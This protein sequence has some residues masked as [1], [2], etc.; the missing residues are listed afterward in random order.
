MNRNRNRYIAKVG[1][2]EFDIG[3]TRHDEDYEIEYDGSKYNISFDKLSNG[4]FL[5]KVNDTV[6]EINISRNNGGLDV[7]ID[8]KE[9]EVRVE[10]YS[11]AELRRK[12]G[13]A[14]DGPEDKIIKAPMPGMVLSV[15]VKTGDPIKK[16]S[17]LLIIEAMK[18]ENMIKAPHDGTVSRVLV[19]AGH[20]VDKNDK[21]LELE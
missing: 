8:G 11:L 5:F 9:L 7:F 15:P 20:A 2:Q 14:G 17:T 3:L 6:S 19:E 13:T 1:K 21:L 12:A 4:K 10:R 16:G 18:M